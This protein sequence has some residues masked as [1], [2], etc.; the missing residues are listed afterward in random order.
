M[1]TPF[2]VPTGSARVILF[3]F[4]TS[5]PTLG[6]LLYFILA[7]LIGVECAFHPGLLSAL[8][9]IWIGEF[10]VLRGELSYAL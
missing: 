2:H 3:G 1:A 8:L 6:M 4:S 5:L 9:T 7:S 10:F